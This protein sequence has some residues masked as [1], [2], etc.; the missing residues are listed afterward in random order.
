MFILN[1]TLFLLIDAMNLAHVTNQHNK[2]G[3]PPVGK[4]AEVAALKGSISAFVQFAKSASELKTSSPAHTSS[5]SL[6]IPSPSV[7]T[8]PLSPISTPNRPRS[9]SSS[10]SF[11]QSPQQNSSPSVGMAGGSQSQYSP[12]QSGATGGNLA[13][14][15]MAAVDQAIL[16]LGTNPGQVCFYFRF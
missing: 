13:Q 3:L 15:A 1:L 5:P 12:L 6:N 8:P 10:Q 16:S 2:T 7:S 9:S 4:E 14:M 11:C